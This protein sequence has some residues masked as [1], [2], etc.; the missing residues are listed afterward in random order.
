M[1]QFNLKFCQKRKRW[2]EIVN[3]IGM[4]IQ[5]STTNNWHVTLPL[6]MPY[7]IFYNFSHAFTI[8]YC[9]SAN[10]RMLIKV[11]LNILSF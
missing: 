9:Y 7:E 6:S 11:K 5:G 3:E 4:L 10:F 2:L 8:K 1:A